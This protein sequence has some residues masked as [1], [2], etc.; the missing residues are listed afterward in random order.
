MSLLLNRVHQVRPARLP[1]FCFDRPPITEA[2]TE[3]EHVELLRER[4]AIA[5]I[6]AW[7]EVATQNERG[8]IGEVG[9]EAHI[10][11]TNM[12]AELLREDGAALGEEL[13]ARAGLAILGGFEGTAGE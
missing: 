1:H 2:V 12:R 9:F 8:L 10:L 4:D 7:R 5:D 13:V 11:D 3:F 6:Q